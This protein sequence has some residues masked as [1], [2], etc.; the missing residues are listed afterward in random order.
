MPKV[1]IAREP[2]YYDV[3]KQK[4]DFLKIPQTPRRNYQKQFSPYYVDPLLRF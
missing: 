4:I 3:F 1:R 2:V